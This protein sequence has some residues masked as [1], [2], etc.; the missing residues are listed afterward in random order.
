MSKVVKI[1]ISAISFLI[2]LFSAFIFLIGFGTAQ[3]EQQAKRYA[4]MIYKT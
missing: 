3:E 1:I 2:T 4:D